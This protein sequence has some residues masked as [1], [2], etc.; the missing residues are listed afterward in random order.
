MSVAV[1]F[2]A[3]L[4]DLRDNL[5][6]FHLP[7]AIAYPDVSPP[8]QAQRAFTTCR[9]LLI[10]L[11]VTWVLVRGVRESAERQHRHGDHQDRARS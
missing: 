2:S 7:A 8:G 4:Q 5:F 6:G 3:Y 11:A 1:G 10:M 9:R